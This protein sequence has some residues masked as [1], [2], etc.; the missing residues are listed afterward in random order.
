MAQRAATREQGQTAQQYIRQSIVDP[1]AYIVEGFQDNIMPKDFSQKFSGQQLNALVAYIMADSGGTA[2]APV[3]T[4]SPTAAPTSVTTGTSV[5]AGSPTAAPTSAAT[6]TPSGQQTSEQATVT[7]T[8]NTFSLEPSPDSVQAGTITFHVTNQATDIPHQL[9][10]IRTDVAAAQLPVDSQD[11]P[12]LSQLD[13]VGQTDDI[14][15]G[16]STDLT[17]DLSAGHYALICAL[18]GHYHAGMY[19]DFT[20]Q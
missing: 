15:P 17:L 5:P 6:G 19:A 11:D 18:H 2:G 10:V 9:T 14:A 4:G 20:V 13:V 3:P 1:S 8:E 16:Q 7:V 12:L